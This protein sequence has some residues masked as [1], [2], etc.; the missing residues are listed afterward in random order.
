M[1]D[2]QTT[3]TTDAKYTP[4]QVGD[5]IERGSDEGETKLYAVIMA[6]GIGARLWPCSLRNRPKQFLDL[7]GGLSLLQETQARLAP[8]I[9]PERTFVS[10]RQELADI[11]ADQLP[12]ISSS[13]V[14]IDLDGSGT[15]SAV[16]LAAMHLRRLDPD[17]T[18]AVLSA[19]HLVVQ[20]DIFR[21]VL[22]AAECV[23]AEN[24]LVA[25]GIRPTSP[26]TGYGYI[27]QGEALPA[28]EGVAAFRA[29]RFLEKPD[30]ATA[31][32]FLADGRHAWNGGMCVWKVQVILDE[33]AAHMPALSAELM[34]IERLH[35]RSPGTPAAAQTPQRV[36]PRV[37]DKTIEA[38]VLENSC[39]V[40]VIPSEFG[41]SDVGDWAAIYDL[42]PHDR[43]GNA[44]VGQHRSLDSVNS[45]IFSKPQ[46][47][48]ATLGLADMIVVDTDEVLLICPR[49]R[50]QEVKELTA[51]LNA[52]GDDELL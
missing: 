51:L 18:M 7:I 13:N 17:A 32:A 34:E 37:P 43:Q 48:V 4:A 42:L 22:A 46:K 11:V 5:R 19:D 1:N 26:E 3:P 27:E 8:L 20:G 12:M 50:A 29:A 41:W 31:E 21:R 2:T 52:P 47:L 10:T 38:G 6:G 23:A 44:V 33:I 36:W 24:W 25:I 16:G 35:D 45:L 28:P 30:L 49:S 39:R 15:A 14:L 40:A 9:P